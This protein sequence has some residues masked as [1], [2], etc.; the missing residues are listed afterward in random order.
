MTEKQKKKRKLKPWCK[1]CRKRHHNICR[2]L[3]MRVDEYMASIAHY[4]SQP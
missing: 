1:E 4:R 3:S 2:A